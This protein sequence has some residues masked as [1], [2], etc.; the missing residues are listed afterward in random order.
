M[1]RRTWKSITNADTD[2]VTC[3]IC[4]TEDARFKTVKLSQ[5]PEILP[6]LKEAF[7]KHIAYLH[8][9]GTTYDLNFMNDMIEYLATQGCIKG[10]G[11]RMSD[12][13]RC[14]ER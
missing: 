3:G 11:L 1:Q 6:P 9:T 8:S 13:F 2:F 14:I 12:M 5:H 7:E 4:G 10:C